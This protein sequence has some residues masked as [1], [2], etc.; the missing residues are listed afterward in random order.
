MQNVTLQ[1]FWVIDYAFMPANKNPGEVS[2]LRMAAAIF[3]LPE[4][5]IYFRHCLDPFH[6][7]PEK[8]MFHCNIFHA[9]Q[10][11]SPTHDG[12]VNA[13]SVCMLEKSTA[14]YNSKSISGNLKHSEGNRYGLC[15]TFWP[16][17][18]K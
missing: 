4:S 6:V 10:P 16:S 9:A 14:N 1:M 3:L 5:E 18:K 15:E 17:E 11:I 12:L 8:T 7:L 13:K 2:S